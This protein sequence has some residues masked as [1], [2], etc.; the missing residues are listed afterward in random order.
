MS[1]PSLSRRTALA[2][3]LAA[4]CWG[5]GTAVSKQA[6]AEVPPV[7]LLAIQL[8]V[9]LAFL[10]LVARRRGER[11]PASRE[12]RLLARLGLLNPGLAYALSLIGLTQIP[13]SLSALLWAIEPILILVLAVLVM[14]ERI[15][16]ALVVLSAIALGGL[17]LILYDPSASGALPGV[18]LT[19]AGAGCCAVY[20]V[21]T[22]HW[23]PHASSTLGVVISQEAYALGFAIVLLLGATLAGISPFPSALTAEGVAS[24]VA[25]GLLYYGLAYWFYLSG[26]RFVAA[27]VAAM[28]FYMIPVFGVASA[29][30]YGERLGLAQW[31]GAAIVVSA[32]AALTIRTAGG[33]HS[34]ARGT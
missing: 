33:H 24:T 10:L 19:I 27:S 26:L 23:L 31:I 34:T 9:S 4:A 16:G 8:A 22:R 14:R 6:V 2:L 3:I 17:V 21:A 28:A 12:G 7:T 13:A 30:A 1:G 18:A 5:V 32:V 25:S 29:A 20:T 11:L 15:G